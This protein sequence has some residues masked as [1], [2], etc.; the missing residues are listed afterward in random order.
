LLD[1]QLWRN[2]RAAWRDNRSERHSP[3]EEWESRLSHRE[4][5]PLGT[6]LPREEP[7]PGF[8]E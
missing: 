1:D 3:M 8:P 5:I 7:H 6:L 4:G 2:N